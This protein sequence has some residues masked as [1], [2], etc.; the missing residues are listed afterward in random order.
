[1]HAHDYK[2]NLIAW[3]VAKSLDV[4]PLSTV[5]GWTG[6][7]GVSASWYYP[8]DKWILARFP[9]LYRGLH[10]N[11]R[12]AGSRGAAPERVA[13]V[14]NGIDHRRF[15]RDDTLRRRPDASSA[16]SRTSIGDSPLGSVGRLCSLKSALICSIR[17]RLGGFEARDRIFGCSLRATGASV[18]FCSSRSAISRARRGLSAGRPLRRM[19][20]RS[21]T[22]SI[23]SF[24]RS[25]D[26]E[27]D[28]NAVLEAMA[29]ETPIIATAAA[30]TSE[31]VR[32]GVDGL[33]V[34]CGDPQAVTNAIDTAL[35][36]LV[37]TRIKQPQPGSGLNENCRSSGAMRRVETISPV[38]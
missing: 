33:I 14:L 31:L 30:S 35:S 36:D 27:G 10:R 37:G 2:T 28:P 17:P 11:T 5:H 9:R 8:A 18:P 38:T 6:H 26:Y 29:L 13:V 12:R 4:V 15:H 21:I 23:S 34:P 32:D 16:F 19:S 1:M 7:W 24:E 20:P 3:A 22:R 25:S